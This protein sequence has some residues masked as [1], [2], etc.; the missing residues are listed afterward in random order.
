MT[1]GGGDVE[2]AKGLALGGDA[3][4]TKR[5]VKIMSVIYTTVASTI[6]NL[7]RTCPK[8]RRAQVVPASKRQQIVRCK[9]CNADVPPPKRN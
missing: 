8:C 2:I 6:L 9:F 1:D 3:Y 7:K 5:E 4:I